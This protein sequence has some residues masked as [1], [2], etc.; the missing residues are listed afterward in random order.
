MV[1]IHTRVRKKKEHKDE[2]VVFTEKGTNEKEE[3]ARVTY[4]NIIMH[5]IFSNVEVYINNQQIYNSN[6]LFA[7]KSYISNNFRA[8][9]SEYKVVLHCEGYDYEQDPEDISN[10]LLD[11]FSTRRMKLLSRPDGFMLYGK[12]MI[13]FFSTSELLYPNMKIR[14][15]LIGAR[16]N[17]YLISDN[18]NVSLGVVDCSLYTRRIAL[19]DD[20]HKKREDML[21]Y[22]PVEYNSSEILEKT[23]I[24][25]GETKSI[26]SRK[27]FQQCSN[28]SSHDCN[29][30][31]LCVHWFFY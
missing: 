3:L 11:L 21:A 22:A 4:V 10:P 17:F 18:P 19:K 30:H 26:H 20:Y 31:K 13:D 28:S 23:I 12:L 1:T 2:S 24:I 27:H 16:P 15:R 9:V 5:S 29:E 14:L 6:G 8:A 7:H 25:A